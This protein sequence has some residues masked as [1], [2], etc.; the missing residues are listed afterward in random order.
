M[1]GCSIYEGQSQKG[2]TLCPFLFGK[3][4]SCEQYNVCCEFGG[5]S[6]KAN[7]SCAKERLLRCR[8]FL[9]IPLCRV[10]VVSAND[11]RKNAFLNDYRTYNIAPL[12]IYAPLHEA[13]S[14]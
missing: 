5:E 8:G 14:S 1:V 4:L 9:A 7:Y 10:G 3:Y 13:A 11:L 6:W 12:D 2:V